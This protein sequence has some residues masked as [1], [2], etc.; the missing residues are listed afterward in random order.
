MR[1]FILFTESDS[2]RHIVLDSELDENHVLIKADQV[3]FIK[4]ALDQMLE[5][6][7]WDPKVD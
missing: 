4:E 3:Q 1:E 6:L 2:G 7:S 5:S